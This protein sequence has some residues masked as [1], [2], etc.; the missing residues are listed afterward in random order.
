MI[1]LRREKL[2][3]LGPEKLADILLNLASHNTSIYQLIDQI[4][5]TEEENTE[6][7]CKRMTSLKDK[8]RGFDWDEECGVVEEFEAL[9]S[10]IKENVKDAKTGLELIMGFYD[11]EERLFESSHE[12][13]YVG[14]FYEDDVKDAFVYFASLFPDKDWIIDQ[15]FKLLE[16]DGFGVRQILL[17]HTAEFLPEHKIREMIERL[18]FEATQIDNDWDR[19]TKYSKMSILARQLKDPELFEKAQYSAFCDDLPDTA[20]IE[21]A[22]VYFESG[23][24]TNALQWLDHLD[25]K[26]SSWLYGKEKLLT[27]IYIKTG[28]V[29]KQRA[30]SWKKFRRSRRKEEFDKLLVGRKKKEKKELI[31][32]E[33]GL[34]FEREKFS[35]NDASFLVEIGRP[36]EAETY[37]LQ[38]ESSVDY[39][40]YD[41]M[42]KLAGAF[43]KNN[44]FL[45]ASL[46]YRKLLVDILQSGRSKIYDKG[47]AYLKKLDVMSTQ[48]TDWD[49]YIDHQTFKEGLIQSYKR[50]YSFWTRYR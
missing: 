16:K 19:K 37:Y 47:V 24:L 20:I 36:V 46:I 6:L 15:I 42:K 38:R 14:L 41:S 18:A 11:L 4:V 3:E 17:K 30:L 12:G 8:F 23:D 26:K 48:I 50:K 34:I 21:I 25:D 44:A 33:V 32:E 43:E 45:T 22:R 40:C 29:E 7:F 27:E 35:E 2:L 31:E 39:Y 9:V 13:A 49:T 1:D 5:S 10:G 28:E